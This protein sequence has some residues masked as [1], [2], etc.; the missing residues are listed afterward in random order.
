LLQKISVSA[1]K[2]L[3]FTARSFLGDEAVRIGLVDR[4]FSSENEVNQHIDDLIQQICSNGQ[5]ALKISKQ[6][7][8]RLVI[9]ALAGEIEQIPAILAN[10]RVSS[11]AREGF[12][13]FLEKRKPNW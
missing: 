10:I 7:I 1:L 5:Q 8:N 13:A 12:S 3:V 6:L 11:E 4:T 9:R 2:E